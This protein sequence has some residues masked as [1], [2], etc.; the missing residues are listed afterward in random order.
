[1]SVHRTEKED[2]LGLLQ[3]I[4]VKGNNAA[5]EQVTLAVE[6]SYSRLLGPSMETETRTELKKRADAEAIRI[7]VENLR[8]LLLTPPLGRKRVLALD[9]GFRTGCKLVCLDAQ[10][11]LLHDDVVYPHSG[12]GAALEAG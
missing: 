8:E 7:F 4:F 5:A 6:D 12:E 10:G 2:A 1:M 3:K 11:K 9:P